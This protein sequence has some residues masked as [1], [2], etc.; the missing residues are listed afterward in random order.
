MKLEYGEVRCHDPVP[1]PQLTKAQ[2]IAGAE[3]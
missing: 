3:S 1:A 2:E